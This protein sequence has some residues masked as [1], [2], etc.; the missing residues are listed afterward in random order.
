MVGNLQSST[1]EDTA[2]STT[3]GSLPKKVAQPKAMDPKA[4]PRPRTSE[5]VIEAVKTLKE[6]GGSSLVAIK[7][8]L[9]A[10]Y[11]LDTDKQAHLIKRCLKAAV[12]SGK[13]VQTK[14]KGAS[15]SFK[16]PSAKAQAAKRNETKLVGA[17]A[18]AVKVA[19]VEK[20][21]DKKASKTGSVKPSSSVKKS[22][23]SKVSRHNVLFS[24]SSISIFFNLICNYYFSF[25]STGGEK[26]SFGNC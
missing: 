24:L 13:L 16:L 11:Q 4:K 14:G 1:E 22:A 2:S 25:L 3:S 19:R 8:A 9:K 6:R 10:M 7:K 5:M 23:S 21:A 15:G 26:R 18:A 20:A 12:A 17:E